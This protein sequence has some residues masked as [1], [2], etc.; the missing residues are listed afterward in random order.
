MSY[1]GAGH[2]PLLLWRGSTGTALELSENG[3]LLGHFPEETYSVV[4]V[5]VEPG[6]RAMLYT[7]SNESAS[8]SAPKLW[9]Y[10]R[11]RMSCRAG[12]NIPRAKISMT[13]S[14]SWRSIS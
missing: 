11:D 12:Q 1:A 9:L 4:Q 2:P 8:S 10:S 14:R 6:D 5:P 7:S 3:L 13:I